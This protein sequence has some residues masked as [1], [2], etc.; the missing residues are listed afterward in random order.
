MRS[1]PL[2]CVV[3]P[4]CQHLHVNST[5]LFSTSPYGE[6]GAG[7]VIS[8]NQCL[9][10]AVP[11]ANLPRQFVQLLWFHTVAAYCI[12]SRILGSSDVQQ[13]AH[14]FLCVNKLRIVHSHHILFSIHI[15]KLNHT[16]H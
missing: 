5:K 7:I 16:L 10:M 8:E 15:I 6:C 1:S 9:A 2:A 12:G 3:L 4:L 11:S 13:V 14:L